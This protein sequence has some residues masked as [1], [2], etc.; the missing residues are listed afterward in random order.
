VCAIFSSRLL[1]GNAPII[2]EDGLQSRDFIHVK[3]I[4]Q[5]LILSMDSNKVKNEVFNVGSGKPTSIKKVAEILA[6]YINPKIKPIITNKF[7]PGDIRHCYADISKIS[8]K[9]GFKPKYSFKDGIKELI[10]WVKSQQGKVSDRS[11]LATKELE[12]KGLLK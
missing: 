11:E 3:D 12:E 1:S 6:E 9:L 2:F 8:S 4:S 10:G 7:R 5:S